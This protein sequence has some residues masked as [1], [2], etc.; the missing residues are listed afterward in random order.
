[1]RVWIALKSLSLYLALEEDHKQVR[2]RVACEL[3]QLLDFLRS[4]LVLDLRHVDRDLASR[5][6]VTTQRSILGRTALA[7]L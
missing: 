6:A 2:V 7:E 1:M 5:H 4:F 3:F